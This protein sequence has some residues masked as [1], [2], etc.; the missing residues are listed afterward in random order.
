MSIPT[1]TE[2]NGFVPL[3]REHPFRTL[4]AKMWPSERERALEFTL[5]PHLDR[6]ALAPAEGPGEL[7]EEENGYLEKLRHDPASRLAELVYDYEAV[8]CP[9]DD[10]LAEAAF[11]LPDFGSEGEETIEAFIDLDKHPE[12]A[13]GKLAEIWDSGVRRTLL[14]RRE[15]T[16]L[17]RCI[18][19]Q[20]PWQERGSG[21]KACGDRGRRFFWTGQPGIGR[22]RHR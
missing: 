10:P 9:P 20:W 2:D 14:V 15:H 5:I 13:V 17:A 16:T 21:D 4:H 12:L 22:S 7:S 6:I 19:A 11:F 1:L 18:F 8:R 3:P